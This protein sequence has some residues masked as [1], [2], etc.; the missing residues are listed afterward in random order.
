VSLP[1]NINATLAAG[2]LILGMVI[3]AAV[4]AGVLAPY[5]PNTPHPAQILEAPSWRHL[6]GTDE[7]G[8]D[9]FSRILYGARPSLLV[10]TSI[11][12]IAAT[13]G[14]LVGCASGLAG[15]IV[16]TGVMRLLEVVMAL[17]GLVI[18]LAL[19][20]ALGPSLVNLALALGLLGI[21]FYARVARAQT[22]TLRERAFVRAARAMGASPWFILHRHIVPNLLPTIVI[23]MSLGLSGALLGAS[24]LSFIGLGAQPPMAEWGALVNASRPYMLDDWWYAVFPGAAVALTSFGFTLLGDGLRDALDPRVGE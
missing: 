9:M 11:V 23:F 18:A 5:A 19:T 24:A 16:D 1:R 3:A 12:V 2:L 8:R 6:A 20:A 17:P 4:L 15:G 21:P 14:V 13:G 7:L 10:A 22:L